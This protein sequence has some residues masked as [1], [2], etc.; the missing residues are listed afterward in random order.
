MKTV[1]PTGDKS[2]DSSRLADWELAARVGW[3][4]ASADQVSGT[5]EEVDALRGEMTTTVARADAL[6][7]E[8]TGLGDGL[9]SAGA[10]VVGR[11]TWIRDNL[12]SLAWLTDPLA[13]QLIVRSGVGREVARKAIGLQLGVVLGYLS[14]KVLGQYEVF[15]P[16][17]VD[18]GRLTLVGPNLLALERTVV[19]DS[20]LS[21]SELR[22]GIC[23]HEIAH[24][25]QFEGVSW[26]RGHLRGLID[27][28]LED[29]RIDPD[30]VR[31][32]VQRLTELLK[33]PSRLTDPARLIEIVLTPDQRDVIGRAQSLMSLLEGHG[34]AVMD[35]GAE[36]AAEHGETVPDP[37]RVRTVLNR[38]RSNAGD[39]ALRKAL[40]LSMKAEQ[41]AVGERFILDV[42]ERHGRE[43][44]DRVWQGPAHIPSDEELRSPDDWAAR[45]AA[46]A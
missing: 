11:R 9:P 21:A 15:L 1:V 3:L 41:Y 22:L 16:G 45:V 24:R 27:A 29:A 5:R 13:D 18:A 35:W 26:L 17:D 46:T 2:D 12:A 19:P 32:T 23:L 40:G 8:A 25:L 4:V 31:A 14:T 38:R 36:V 43:V 20:G 42:A 7:R 30:R 44:F 39:Q 37:S 34:N 33:D 6:A 28:Y 10:R